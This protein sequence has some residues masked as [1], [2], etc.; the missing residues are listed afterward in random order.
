MLGFGRR[1]LLTVLLALAACTAAPRTPASREAPSKP[2]ALAGSATPAAPT[3]PAPRQLELPTGTVSATITPLWVAIERGIFRRYGLEVELA[4]VA[5]NT[6]TQAVQ[7]GTAP[8][9]ATTASTVTAYANGARNLTIIAGMLNKVL[10]QLVA[11]PEI[12]RA[13][14]LRGKAVGASAPG[15]SAEIALGATLQRLRLDAERDVTILHVRDQPA[16][17]ASL[18]SGQVVAGMMSNPYNQQALGQGYRLLF[19]TAESD[20]EILGL[21]IASTREV[22]DR[23][24]DLARR[25]VMAYVEAVQYA[26]QEPAGTVEAMMRG[27]RNEDRALAEDAYAMYRKVWDPWPSARALRV[28]LDS[29]D[30]PEARDLQPE[31]LIETGILRELEVSGWLGQHLSPP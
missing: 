28:L 9:A 10:F 12:A 6:A 22:L 24:P 25:F 20:I 23:E 31:E 11:S 16:I 7:T 29:L 17:L 3:A 14:D 21:H 2:A 15:S 5:P 18:L 26:R 19:D 4:G 30:V 27:T 13:E 1:L 8:F